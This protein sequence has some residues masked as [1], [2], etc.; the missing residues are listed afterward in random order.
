M[1]IRIGPPIGSQGS[2]PQVRAC[3][4]EEKRRLRVA[5]SIQSF[6]DCIP[7]SIA[8]EHGPP[9]GRRPPHERIAGAYQHSLRQNLD[10]NR[11]AKT[12]HQVGQ[13][14]RCN[15]LALTQTG[16]LVLVSHFMQRDKRVPIR[17]AVVTT[18]PVHQQDPAQ[19]EV[20]T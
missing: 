6:Q 8:E 15:Q 18:G 2:N 20:L 3:R 17:K 16:L 19:P 9:T 13:H 7:T 12:R 1:T 14:L 4:F 11:P 10:R 5:L